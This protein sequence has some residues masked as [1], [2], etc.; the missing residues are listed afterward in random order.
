MFW[1]KEVDTQDLDGIP[2]IVQGGRRRRAL[3]KWMKPENQTLLKYSYFLKA[4][5]EKIRFGAQ[6]RMSS[7][8]VAV[9]NDVSASIDHV[10]HF[11]P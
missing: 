10:K 8:Q 4:E 11:L 1:K 9:N 5:R 3:D 6:L 7:S 2:Q